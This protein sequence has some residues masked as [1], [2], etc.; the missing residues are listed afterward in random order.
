MV[1]AKSIAGRLQQGGR[2]PSLK[3]RAV[4]PKTGRRSSL[5]LVT[6][7]LY[8]QA[9]TIPETTGY[10]PLRRLANNIPTLNVRVNLI[11]PG[12]AI[13]CGALFYAGRDGDTLHSP[14]LIVYICADEIQLLHITLTAYKCSWWLPP[15][16]TGGGKGNTGIP[17]S[18]RYSGSQQANKYVPLCQSGRR[19]FAYAPHHPA[20]RDSGYA[21]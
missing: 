11:Q 5:N 19:Q 21:C 2:Q 12:P 3:P 9:A 17:C 15:T 4:V 13:T 20:G 10:Y 6:P 8:R 16:A 7:V 18:Q 1:A 14:D